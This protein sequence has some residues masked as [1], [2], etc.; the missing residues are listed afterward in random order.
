MCLDDLSA[1][2]DWFWDFDDVALFERSLP[3]PVG[4]DTMRE[5]WRAALSASDPPKACWYIAET[6]EKTPVAIAGLQAINY[7][8][9]DAV[10]P[11]FVSKPMR[12][13][14]VGT[15]LTLTL[16]NLAFDRLRLHRLTTFYR[17]DNETTHRALQRLGFTE[18]GRTREGWFADG[19][20]RDQVQV[21]LLKTEWLARRAEIPGGDKVYSEVALDDLG[22]IGL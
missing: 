3:F 4:M 14:G 17:D 9:G 12:G 1:I 7:I 15:A 16:L 20:R 22:P 6:A 10:L 13:K 5:S 2:A 11:M 19:V 18:E 21:G 8:H